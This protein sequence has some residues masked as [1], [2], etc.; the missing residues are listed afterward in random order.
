MTGNSQSSTTGSS[1]LLWPHISLHHISLPQESF[2][3][4]EQHLSCAKPFTKLCASR[5][6]AFMCKIHT[7]VFF[8]LRQWT[9]NYFS[10]GISL[11]LLLNEKQSR[12]G[13]NN[14][15]LCSHSQRNSFT[16]TQTTS[17]DKIV[18]STGHLG[19]SQKCCQIGHF[20]AQLNCWTH[21]VV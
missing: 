10:A 14:T 13:C 16:A 21:T 4:P 19:Y 20:K 2:R 12:I 5:F 9:W 11:V 17:P 15:A 1:L 6:I 8:F 18:T 3:L 7:W